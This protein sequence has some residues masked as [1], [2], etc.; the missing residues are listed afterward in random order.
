M[1]DE[2]IAMC[3][4]C[5]SVLQCV[6]ECCS[7]L[8]CRCCHEWQAAKCS[9]IAPFRSWV[10][11]IGLFCMSVRHRNRLRQNATACNRLQHTLFKNRLQHTL[12]TN[13]LQHTIST[14]FWGWD[15]RLTYGIFPGT[16]LFW[17]CFLKCVRV[18]SEGL[19]SFVCL[20]WTS[21][22][23]SVWTSV[24]S[25]CLEVTLTLCPRASAI[26]SK[27][28]ILFDQIFG[29]CLNVVYADIYIYVNI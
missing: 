11:Y 28:V 4:V 15:C 1:N 29:M 10:L 18:L 6:A 8:V 5:C 27:E 23:C 19:I 7:A 22:L 16:F 3:W 25:V 21:F 14:W 17:T 12:F 2:C 26:Y 13:R 9:S 20:F 24:K